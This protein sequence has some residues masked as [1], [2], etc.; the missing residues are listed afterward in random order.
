MACRNGSESSDFRYPKPECLET[1]TQ[2]WQGVYAFF[3]SADSF[4]L[5][6]VNDL[7]VHGYQTL[8]RC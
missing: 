5:K 2:R 1:P 6:V 4:H 8:T 7:V 3:R